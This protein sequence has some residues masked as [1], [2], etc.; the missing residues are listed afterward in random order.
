MWLHTSCL[1][2]LRKRSSSVFVAPQ[3]AT[4]I[5]EQRRG[6]GDACV[7]AVPSEYAGPGSGSGDHPQQYYLRQFRGLYTRR[8][9]H[10]ISQLISLE[11]TPSSRFFLLQQK[12]IVTIPGP[13][14]IYLTSKYPP[15]DQHT[16][17]LPPRGSCV[18]VLRRT[19]CGL[20]ALVAFLHWHSIY[21]DIIYEQ[22]VFFK[23]NPL[24]IRVCLYTQCVS[25]CTQSVSLCFTV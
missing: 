5:N 12:K 3:T 4:K 7:L 11:E 15:R 13:W 25:R 6:L 16:S 1:C 24:Y 18:P 14:P 20:V 17:T 23:K 19:F 21:L 2:S 22:S 8:R 10:H 9:I